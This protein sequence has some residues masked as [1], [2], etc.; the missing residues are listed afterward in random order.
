[1][2][3]RQ[4]FALRV[5]SLAAV[6]AFGHAFAQTEEAEPPEIVSRTVKIP[7]LPLDIAPED[8]E[9]ASAPKPIYDLSG[10]F[11]PFGIV[12]EEGSSIRY[13]PETGKMVIRAT[14]SDAAMAESMFGL[15]YPLDSF[16]QDSEYWLK[17]IKEKSAA[18]YLAEVDES[19][20][21]FDP[22]L[23][24]YALELEN[25]KAIR[26]R[27]RKRDPGASEELALLDRKIESLEKGFSAD[28]ARSKERIPAQTATARETTG[29][30]AANRI[31]G[32][33]PAP[34]SL[35]QAFRFDEPT[36]LAT[37]FTGTFPAT[38]FLP[39]SSLEF[40][41]I[42]PRTI[43]LRD[44][45]PSPFNFEET[46]TLYGLTHSE[47]GGKSFRLSPYELRK[48]LPSA[49]RIRSCTSYGAV[50]DILG[51]PTVAAHFVDRHPSLNIESDY[52][53]LFQPLTESSLRVL[54]V[55]ISRRFLREN[56]TFLRPFTFREATFTAEKQ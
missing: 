21:S 52:W 26:D 9:I 30:L 3:P 20:R 13:S 45:D 28:F 44:P 39:E 18:E 23:R 31:V 54:Q 53:L 50:S 33:R 41:S 43:T 37:T 12:L 47:D 10:L 6:V 14:E 11:A 1:M 35:L 4:E 8:A 32:N 5:G 16:V 24:A 42:V 48:S 36:I 55:E 17:S 51:K 46:K 29:F 25:V 15:S 19:R 38:E 27:L 22:I 56:G 49:E 7:Y 34:E 2:A 40:N